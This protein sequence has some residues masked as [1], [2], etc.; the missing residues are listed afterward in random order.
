[1]S[2]RFPKKYER[3]FC[4]AKKTMNSFFFS[5]PE[6]ISIQIEESLSFFETWRKMTML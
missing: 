2:D 6:N 1:M 4:S 5:K 3:I